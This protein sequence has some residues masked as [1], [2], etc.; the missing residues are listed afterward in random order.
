MVYNKTGPDGQPALHIYCVGDNSEG[1]LFFDVT[2]DQLQDALQRARDLAA[3]DDAF[4]T[5]GVSHDEPVPRQPGCPDYFIS[6]HVRAKPPAYGDWYQFEI[7]LFDEA[8]NKV[9]SVYFNEIPINALEANTI[10]L[11]PR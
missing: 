10:D 9:H 6:V 11:P 4:A 2:Q 3:A 1:H 8:E 5:V 7:R